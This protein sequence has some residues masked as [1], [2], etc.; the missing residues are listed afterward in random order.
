M[1]VVKPP[2]EETPAGNRAN[3]GFLPLTKGGSPIDPPNEAHAGDH[4]DGSFPLGGMAPQI[5]P[6]NHRFQV[7]MSKMPQPPSAVEPGKGAVPVYPWDSSG[8]PNKTRLPEA[9]M[10]RKK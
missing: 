8:M 2:N 6:P 5:T 9:D 10:A 1:G 3:N 7:G 4:R